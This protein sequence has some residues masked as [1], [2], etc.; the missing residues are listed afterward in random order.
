LETKDFKS[1]LNGN[2]AGVNAVI[3]FYEKNKAE[4][5]KEKAVEK[6]IKLK[7]KGKLESSIKSK[8]A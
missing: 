7:A 8:L 1:E 5:G 2:V 3:S 4:I 6:Y